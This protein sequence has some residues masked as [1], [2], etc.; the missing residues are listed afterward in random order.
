MHAGSVVEE[1]D[2][3]DLEGEA[4]VAFS[5][6]VGRCLATDGDEAERG[7]GAFVACWDKGAVIVS[8][9][10]SHERLESRIRHTLVTNRQLYT[11]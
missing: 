7:V 10:M 6:D 3:G 8:I 9:N 1:F 4:G 5:A 11:Q 2:V